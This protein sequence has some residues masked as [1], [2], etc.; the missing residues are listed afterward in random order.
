MALQELYMSYVGENDFWKRIAGACMIAALN[1][2]D[3]APATP[4][5]A[6]RLLWAIE[7]RDNVKS[8]ARKMLVRVLQDSAIAADV[9]ASTDPMVQSAVDGL[10]DTY[11]TG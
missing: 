6:N 3:E 9:E 8:M 11:A 7:V 2:A 5:H 1:I 10:V 4:N